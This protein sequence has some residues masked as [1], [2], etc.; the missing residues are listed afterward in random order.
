MRE[1][2]R[3]EQLVALCWAETGGSWGQAAVEAGLPASYGERVRRKLKRLGSRHIQRAAAA[4]DTSG[5][6]FR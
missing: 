6:E 5:G 1:L 3:E 2:A 4:A